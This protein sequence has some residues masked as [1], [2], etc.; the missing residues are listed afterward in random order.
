VSA[1]L[2]PPAVTTGSTLLTRI[3]ATVFKP[4]TLFFQA[5]KPAK[6]VG[7]S[8]GK[9][10]ETVTTLHRGRS[11]GWKLP[12]GQ[13]RDIHLPATIRAAAR[14][15]KYRQTPFETAI[16]LSLE[17]V[18]EKL[19]IYKAPMTIIFMI[20]LSGSMLLRIEEVKEALLKLH[21]DAY[22]YRDKVGLV[23]LKD[24]GAIV[25]QHPISNLRVVASQL[26][27]LRI[28]GLTPLAAGMLKSLEVLKEAQRRDKS[29][30]PVMVII[31]DGS[32][33]IPLAKSLQTGE[34]RSIDETRAIV[35]EYEDLAVRDVL[36]VAKVVRK[37][38][39]KTIVINTNPH[40]YGRETYGFA[41]TEFIA[42]TTSGSHH[43]IGRLTRGSDLV[44]SMMEKIAGDQRLI[45][46]EISK[47][48][49]D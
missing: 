25:V 30:I 37:Q 7:C 11:R 32:A 49:F 23:A 16:R 48:R 29:T 17:D 36:D 9:R 14:R 26:L 12:Y 47:R 2:K 13:P 39:I 10:G 31:T 4:F 46:H 27:K 8:A 41:V 42:R 28:S 18:K 19:R 1:A 24:M 33:N 43:A 44:E 35:R 34:R 40:L 45:S 5:R 6:A 15:Q 3:A 22:R 21:Q 38:G 20:D